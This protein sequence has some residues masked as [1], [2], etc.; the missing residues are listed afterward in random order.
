ML[1]I[2]NFPN[3][4]NQNCPKCWQLWL[5]EMLTIIISESRNSYVFTYLQPYFSEMLAIKFSKR[6]VIIIIIIPGADD[7]YNWNNN[8]GR[9]RQLSPFRRMLR[10]VLQVIRR[11]IGPWRVRSCTSCSSA[12]LSFFFFIS[13]RAR[14]GPWDPPGQKCTTWQTLAATKSTLW[15]SKARFFRVLGP[16]GRRPKMMI[17]WHRSKHQKSDD[18]SNLGG[19]CRHFGSKNMTFEDPFGIVFSSFFWMT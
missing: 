14:G 1:A 7:N 9:R 17:F 12:P 10:D 19:P 16:S 6:M 18:K 3:A 8:S 15:R 5:S 2:I 4:D 13:P 11:A